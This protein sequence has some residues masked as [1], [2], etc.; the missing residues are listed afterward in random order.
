VQAKTSV[1]TLLTTQLEQAKL[2]EAK[3][4][5][6]INVLEWADTP[7]VPV[8]PKITRNIILSLIAG[9]FLGTF[10]V[11]IIEFLEHMDKD[12]ETAPKWLEMKNSVKGLFNFRKRLRF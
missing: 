11:F 6:T 4:I 5:P 10:I 8:K 9:L 12:P 2:D 3:D 7:T 1:V